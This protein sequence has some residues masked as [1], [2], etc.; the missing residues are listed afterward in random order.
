MKRTAGLLEKQMAA[1]VSKHVLEGLCSLHF[2]FVM[3]DCVGCGMALRQNSCKKTPKGYVG[4]RVRDYLR[5]QKKES[6]IIHV[7][8]SR[9]PSHKKKETL[10]LQRKKV[11]TI[12]KKRLSD[13]T[14]LRISLPF[15]VT[16]GGP[17]H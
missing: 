13:C 15:S 12:K 5:I 9:R 6:K 8:E 3:K 14:G 4:G 10:Q 16:E 7:T 17:R 1:V 2:F 11:T